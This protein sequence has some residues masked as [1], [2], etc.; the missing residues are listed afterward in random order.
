MNLPG[1]EQPTP[2]KKLVFYR[3]FQFCVYI[4]IGITGFGALLDAISNAVSIISPMVTYAVSIIIL[5]V[6]LIQKPVLS[7]YPVNWKISNGQVV[8]LRQIG[9]QMKLA[10]L[11]VLMLLWL[12]RIISS[13]DTTKS[14]TSNSDA[15]KFEAHKPT[16]HQPAQSKRVSYLPIIQTNWFFPRPVLLHALEKELRLKRRLAVWGMGGSGK[17]QTVAKLAKE[18]FQRAEFPVVLWLSGD[19]AEAFQRG[20]VELYPAL[21]QGERVPNLPTNDPNGQRQAVLDYLRQSEEY[22]LICDNID[23]PQ[24]MSAVWPQS[25]QGYIIVT[26][27]RR[28]VET[29]GLELFQ[30]GLL[31]IGESVNFLEARYRA[32]NADEG[33]AQLAL[34]RE[35]GGLPLALTQAAAFLRAHGSRY[36][37]YLEEYRRQRT[38]ILDQKLPADYPRSVSATWQLSIERIRRDSPASAELLQI[39]AWLDGDGIPEEIFA[40]PNDHLPEALRVGLHP[41][42][43]LALDQVLGP[44]IDYAFVQR[45]AQDRRF[46][47]HRLV[48]TVVQRAQTEKDRRAYL[49]AVVHQVD[50]VFPVPEYT[51]WPQCRRLLPQAHNLAIEIQNEDMLDLMA[52]RLLNHAGVFLYSQG[53]FAAAEPLYRQTV[54]IF[55]K[56]LPPEHY[57]LSTGRNNLAT[58]LRIEGKLDESEKLHRLVLANAE[59]T[60]SAESPHLATIIGNL[61]LLLASQERIAESEVLFRRALKIRQ[62]ALPPEHP[63]IALSLNNLA[64]VLSKQK[65]HSEAESLLRKAIEIDQKAL[66]PQ[67]PRFAT[68]INALALV[69]Y[70]QG[71]WVEAEPFFRR[72]LEIRKQALGDNHPDVAE[73]LS[74]LGLLLKDQGKKSEAE[75]AF[76]QALSIETKAMPPGHKF[77]EDARHNLESVLN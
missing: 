29:L 3:I 51:N 66:K 73:S 14:I 63:E 24:K 7:R 34:A 28:E 70:R 30:I 12:P 8:Q 72:G 16:S 47:I 23:D 39:C 71:R 36:V 58:L 64:S 17:T 61:A 33:K 67:D 49:H 75:A 76:Q 31:D 59:R 18:L 38:G 26:S 62:K 27:R 77:I 50:G 40:Q 60:M 54:A 15:T 6:M 1:T 22:L 48:Q 52:G 65:R 69:L 9:I 56:I 41:D 35:L 43:R 45:N 37:D 2:R 19:N 42:N 44:L 11:G 55:E 21:L 5:S 32:Q 53:Q 25:L 10:L 20:L 46:S 4:L 13:S 68:D 74:G 57:A